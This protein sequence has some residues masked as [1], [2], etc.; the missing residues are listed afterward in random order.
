MFSLRV[1]LNLKLSLRVL[2]N[3]KTAFRLK[4]SFWTEK[5]LPE[6]FLKS[7]FVWK[8]IMPLTTGRL[9]FVCGSKKIGY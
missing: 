4:S 3:L 7:F 6:A 8:R 9:N 5:K 1:L 2:L